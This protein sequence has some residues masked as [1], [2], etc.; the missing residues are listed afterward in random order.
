MIS[1]PLGFLGIGPRQDLALPVI[2]VDAEH[3]LAKPTGIESTAAA[4]IAGRLGVRDD[5]ARFPVENRGA[6]NCEFGA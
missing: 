5:V 4:L 1:Q 3:A 2:Q 6:P